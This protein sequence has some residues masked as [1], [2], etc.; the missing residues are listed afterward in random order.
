[1]SIHM[2]AQ[3]SE[4]YAT[5]SSTFH[6]AINW[7]DGERVASH[8]CL[9]GASNDGSRC[10]AAHFDLR[11]KDLLCTAFV[12]MRWILFVFVRWM[13]APRNKHPVSIVY[14][15]WMTHRGRARE[16]ER[17]V[18]TI[19]LIFRSN[20]SDQRFGDWKRCG[21]HCNAYHSLRPPYNSHHSLA[22][23]LYFDFFFRKY[24]CIVFLS[25][26]PDALRQPLKIIREE[27]KKKNT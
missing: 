22:S 26:T 7:C 19:I 10:D 5:A 25:A 15:V 17:E 9:T 4:P 2:T 14:R 12:I 20:A 11:L 16:E 18:E 8:N 23:P 13:N 1:M 27:A 6:R 24:N 21:V 3:L